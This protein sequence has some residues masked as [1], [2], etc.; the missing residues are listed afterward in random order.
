MPFSQHLGFVDYV[1]G[2]TRT[3]LMHRH[4][5]KPKH[6]LPYCVLLVSSIP[7]G[8]PRPIISMFRRMMLNRGTIRTGG[9]LHVLLDLYVQRGMPVVSPYTYIST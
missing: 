7:F 3:P 2:L 9:K 6:T 1:G 4:P 8:W 5:G